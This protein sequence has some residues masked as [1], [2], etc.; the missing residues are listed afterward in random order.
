MALP[1]TRSPARAPPLPRL[2]GWPL[3]EL[4]KGTH[5]PA[6]GVWA[7]GTPR[8]QKI[9]LTRIGRKAREGSTSWFCCEEM[10]DLTRLSER[11]LH[12]S[13]CRCKSATPVARDFQRFCVRCRVLLLFG[14]VFDTMERGVQHCEDQF[15]EIAVRHGLCQ[16]RSLVMSLEETLRS[17]DHIPS[18]MLGK[19][20]D[21][22]RIAASLRVFLEVRPRPSP[23][24]TVVFIRLCLCLPES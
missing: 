3:R 20:V 12:P 17:H 19:P 22:K 4:R 13:I 1:W 9:V 23:L 18:M 10:Q 16:P 5:R 11:W 6:L 14:R 21:Y 8:K 24:S 7:R 2:P 15:L